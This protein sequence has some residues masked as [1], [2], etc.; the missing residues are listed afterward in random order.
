MAGPVSKPVEL[1]FTRD[2]TRRYVIW[3]GEIDGQPIVTHGFGALF[4]ERYLPSRSA[5]TSIWHCPVRTCGQA[6]ATPPDLGDHF[7]RFHAGSILH[8]HLDGTFSVRSQDPENAFDAICQPYVASQG[9]KLQSPSLRRPSH[10]NHF[11]LGPGA[12]ETSAIAV[13]RHDKSKPRTGNKPPSSSSEVNSD[14]ESG[15]DESDG[16]DAGQSDTD[17]SDGSG[18]SDSDASDTDEAEDE[19][20]HQKANETKLQSNVNSEA[21]SDDSDTN[22]NESRG[23]KTDQQNKDK[24]ACANI[25]VATNYPRNVGI[26]EEDTDRSPPA[27]SPARV[28]EDDKQQSDPPHCKYANSDVWKYIT[29]FTSDFLPV[30]AD[31]CLLELLILPRQRDLPYCWKRWL[32]LRKPSLKTLTAV[33]LYL[34]G[35]QRNTPCGNMRCAEF[36]GLHDELHHNGDKNAPRFH[37]QFAFDMCIQLP[38]YLRKVSP[39]LEKRFRGYYCCN[40]YF[41]HNTKALTMPGTFVD[42]ST[43]PWNA[44]SK[45]RK[46]N[47]DEVIPAPKKA[48]TLQAHA[49][50]KEETTNKWDKKNNRMSKSGTQ[51]AKWETKWEKLPHNGRPLDSGPPLAY[52][53]SHYLEPLRETFKRMTEPSSLWLSREL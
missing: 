51:P 26:Q 2:N 31:L 16:S 13:D 27:T 17:D 20:G 5:E 8:D 11:E 38:D 1:V 29:S 15:D 50:Q 47:N 39:A 35:V 41:R 40:A 23:R 46:A 12:P 37:P 52:S 33:A 53:L 42:P 24:P 22:D 6:Y 3:K 4:P 14:D 7:V 19:V 36:Q 45:K 49:V 18:D 28:A 10:S 32:N 43:Q 30:P 21:S 9:H 48:K 44:T 34:G 25:E